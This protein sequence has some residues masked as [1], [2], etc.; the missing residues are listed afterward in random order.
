MYSCKQGLIEYVCPFPRLLFPE[1]FYLSGV[2][3]AKTKI[4]QMAP[5]RK[6]W[7]DQEGWA[8]AWSVCTNPRA[9]G[10]VTEP[11]TLS[12]DFCL[13][14]SKWQVLSVVY[15]WLLLAALMSPEEKF[16]KKPG[17][18]AHITKSTSAAPS[19]FGNCEWTVHDSVPVRTP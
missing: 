10:A 12:L 9:A 18:F 8:Q 15:L 19:S 1:Q 14:L 2:C 7:L 17:P 4:K 5:L 3:K 6:N 13:S 16:G 11:A